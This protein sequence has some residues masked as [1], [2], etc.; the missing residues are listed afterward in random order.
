MF[1]FASLY[2][3]AVHFIIE[4]S[5]TYGWSVFK[6]KFILVKGPVRLIQAVVPHK[7]TRRKGKIINVRSISVL[8]PG[9]WIG[10]YA[11]SKAAL[12]PF[13]DSLRYVLRSIFFFLQ[14]S[15]KSEC[16]QYSLCVLY[17]IHS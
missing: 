8:A 10:A 2:V 15:Y 16:S 17:I 1:P 3:H 4:N 14:F 5:V 12:H 11:A 13:T 7:A 6:K 9:P